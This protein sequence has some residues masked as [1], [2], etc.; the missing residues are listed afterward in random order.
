MEQYNYDGMPQMLAPEGN[1]CQS[2]MQES[3]IQIKLKTLKII[4]E[5]TYTQVP[6]DQ[7]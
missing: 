1:M 6:H 2:R 7:Q 3:V 5:F 4:N